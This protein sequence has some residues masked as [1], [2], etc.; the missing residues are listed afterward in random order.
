[1]FLHHAQMCSCF[2]VR[3]WHKKMRGFFLVFLNY[4]LFNKKNYLVSR[5]NAKFIK[6]AHMVE[7]TFERPHIQQH[8]KSAAA[9][10]HTILNGFSVAYSFEF[11]K[12]NYFALATIDGVWRFFLWYYLSCV[13]YSLQLP[14]K[15][16]KKCVCIMLIKFSGI[17]VDHSNSPPFFR[18]FTIL[19]MISIFS[20][21]RH[22]NF[23][24]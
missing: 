19:S 14:Y 16:R 12:I 5:H 13:L 24:L 9:L 8:S 10:F 1:M 4:V 3:K 18:H 11:W 6:Q 22:K 21:L 23:F 2:H 20:S 7:W 15:I 17:W